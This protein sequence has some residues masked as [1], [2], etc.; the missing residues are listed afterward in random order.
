MPGKT[1]GFAALVKTEALHVTVTHCF[2]HQYAV[3]CKTIPSILREI[4]SIVVK[5]FYSS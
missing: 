1:S 5:V 3:G 4:L 2:V